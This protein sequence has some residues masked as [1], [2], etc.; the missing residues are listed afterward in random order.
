LNRIDEII[1]FHSLCKSE[2]REI[3][4]IQVKR[5]EGRLSDRSMALKLSDAALDFL[6]EVG[7]DP[8][9]GARPL[10]RAI[11]RELE[12]QIAKEILR[13]NFLEGDTI[14]VDVGD[15][16]RLEFKRLPAM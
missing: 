11:Q 8:V 12:T 6:A 15:T 1:I 10:K 5:L 16:E 14:F 13:G 7:F 4:K 3:V 2:L 9:Y